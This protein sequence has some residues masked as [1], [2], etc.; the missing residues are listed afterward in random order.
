[1]SSFAPGAL[2]GVRVLDLTQFVLGPYATQTLGDLGAD[3][4]KVEE[5]TGDRQ[6][7]GK[8]PN[9]KTMGPTYVAL[10]RNKRS[11]VLNLKE[12]PGRRALRRL[13]KTADIFIHNMRPE[14]IARLGFDYEAAKVIKPD[15]VYVEAMGY[16]PAGPYAGRQAFDDLIQSAAGA[17]GLTA[18]V[19]KDAVFRPLPTIIADKT[20]GL[21]AAIA[22]LAALRHKERTGEGQYVCV[23]M[24]ETFT[25][26]LMAEHLYGETYLPA[27]GHFG[28]TTTITPHRRPFRTKDGWLSVL[29]ANREQSARYLALGGIPNA[30]ETERFT[31]APAGGGR[32]DAYYGMMDEATS[33][34]TTEEWMVLC[35]ENNIPA[36]RANLPEEIFDDPQLKETLFETRELEGEGAYRAMKPGLRF[37]KTPVSIR[38][39]PPPLGRD[40]DEVLAEIGADA[41]TV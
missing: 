33:T 30:Y 34:R 23:P 36:M 12:E 5:P 9:S 20:C 10:N 17:C 41:E 24:L 8:A 21:F 31:S 25:G 39:D 6:R 40:T 28:H 15:V 7:G 2:D 11:V 35:A 37:S 16:D 27:T 18:M 3:V 22:C 14:A 32:V 19:D 38:R 29:P 13:L 4:I 1:M 26:F